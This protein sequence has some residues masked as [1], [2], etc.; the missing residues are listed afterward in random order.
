VIAF[1][2]PG[3]ITAQ[4]GV[5]SEILPLRDH[6]N[7]TVWRVSSLTLDGQSPF[8]YGLNE[9]FKMLR[10]KSGSRNIIFISDGQT[11]N[12]ALRQKTREKAM[13]IASMGA[14]I[15]VVGAGTDTN[16]NGVV[17][18][19]RD[20]QFLSQIAL[21]GNGI[22]FPIDVKNR[23]KVIFGESDQDKEFLNS[24]VLLDTNHFITR[25]LSIDSTVSG[26]NFVVPKPSARLLVTTNKKIPILAAWRFGLGRV[27]ALATDDGTEWAGLLLKRNTS[28]LITRT[29]NWAIGDL[30][31]KSAYDI[32]I[33]DTSLGQ[34]TTIQLTSIELPDS[35]IKFRKEGPNKY[36]AD[37]S[38]DTLGIH[39][40]M[41]AK[42]AVNNP[43]EYYNLGVNQNFLSAVEDTGGK[44][45]N[46]EDID[47]ILEAIKT[48]SK[49]PKIEII[50]YS[51]ILAMLALILLL[52]EII[53][54]RLNEYRINR[55]G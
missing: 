29:V 40:V 20:D 7:T 31:R 19:T 1:S 24:L 52:L 6:L 28:E 26:Y 4:H 30:N 48:Q 23:L 53:I 42:V 14:K 46:P 55:G 17:S 8:D 33:A 44:I 35:D 3:G 15:Y 25:S 9:A 50:S 18:S 10:Q 49:K 27:A 38:S 41:G 37:Y 51:W 43:E 47:A 36:L 21:L 45:F 11:T 13:E 12:E 5:I 16:V 39:E 22:Y 54:R 32:S 2:A 34:P